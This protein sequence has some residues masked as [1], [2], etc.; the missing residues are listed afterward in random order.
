M[1]SVENGMHANQTVRHATR[2]AISAKRHFASVCHS[3]ENMSI[4]QQNSNH[5]VLLLK[6]G[7]AE[8]ICATYC[9]LGKEVPMLIYSGAK[10]SVL[11]VATFRQ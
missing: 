6:T 5:E 1:D 11:N 10:V 4:I 3:P 7:I 2:L 9:I 8:R